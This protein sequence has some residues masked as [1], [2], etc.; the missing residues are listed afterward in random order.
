MRPLRPGEGILL[1]WHGGAAECRVVAAAG[2]YVLLR[3]SRI[4]VAPVGR[5]TL[6]TLAGPAVG[7]QG[8]VELAAHPHELRFRVSD[9]GRPA[10]RRAAVR[11]PVTAPVQVRADE[12]VV[13]TQL[14]DVSSRGMRFRRSGR[15]PA[16]ARVRVHA[17]LPDGPVIDADAVVRV[18]R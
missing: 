18:S 3:P 2:S 14:L 9:R 12:R 17:R 8:D 16:G 1:S 15:L 4:T 11:V 10:A 13:R 6:T 7:W 5:A